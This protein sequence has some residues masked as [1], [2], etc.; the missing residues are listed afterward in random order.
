MVT[1]SFQFCGFSFRNLQWCLLCFALLAAA[2]GPIA[3]EP[4]LRVDVRLV[5]LDL[6]MPGQHGG[7][8]LQELRARGAAMPVVLMSGYS[9]SDVG[10][11]FAGL[12]LAGFLHKPFVAQD[13]LRRIRGALA[14]EAEA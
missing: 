7:Q 4:Q 9:E 11:H 14:P 5:L 10:P 13:L 8:V 2:P 12:G 3:Q 6:T 1:R